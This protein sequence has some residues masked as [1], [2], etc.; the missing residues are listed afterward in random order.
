MKIGGFA[1]LG[2]FRRGLRAVKAR[3]QA[4]PGDHI[5]NNRNQDPE[6]PLT[7]SPPFTGVNRG[8]QSTSCTHLV[9]LQPAALP[10]RIKERSSFGAPK[11]HQVGYELSN[12]LR[13]SLGGLVMEWILLGTLMLAGLLVL[14]LVVGGILSLVFWLISLPFRIL[15][16]LVGAAV[17]GIKFVFLAP[18][19]FLC[20]CALLMAAPFII[21]FM[22]IF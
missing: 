13:V 9:A 21:L 18:L 1:I 10:L 19:L 20:C 22:M 15:G 4:Y 12:L 3:P 7:S 14:G 2:T 5:K 17:C 16:W 11:P 8:P 6:H